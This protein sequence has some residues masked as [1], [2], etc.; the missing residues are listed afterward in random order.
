MTISWWLTL[1][2]VL[3]VHCRERR[4]AGHL[5]NLWVCSLSTNIRC[6][7]I[8]LL[9]IIFNG[10]FVL[11]YLTLWVLAIHNAWR[12]TTNDWIVSLP[13]HKGVIKKKQSGSLLKAKHNTANWT[14]RTPTETKHCNLQAFPSRKQCCVITH[15]QYI[16]P[17]PNVPTQCSNVSPNT[18]IEDVVD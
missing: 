8:L 1:A 17:I 5:C 16:L 4:G 3:S 18:T 10:Y 7:C 15:E 12:C 14:Q 13:L 11:F 2:S 6:C 9:W